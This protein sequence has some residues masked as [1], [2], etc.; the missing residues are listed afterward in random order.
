MHELREAFEALRAQHEELMMADEELREDWNDSLARNGLRL[1]LHIVKQLVELHDGTV[2]AA[3]AGEGEG[4][5]VT[6]YLP[7]HFDRPAPSEHR[8]PVEGRSLS[9]LAVLVVDE[10]ARLHGR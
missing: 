10:A 6:V 8:L 5:K 2:E 1:G 3:S 9:R 4:T 7:L